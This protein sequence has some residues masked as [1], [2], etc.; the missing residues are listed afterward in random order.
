M[1]LLRLP[2]FR[3]ST[4]DLPKQAVVARPQDALEAQ[5]ARLTPIATKYARTKVGDSAPEVVQDAFMSLWDV[6]YGGGTETPAND[7]DKL[8]YRILRRRIVDELRDVRR[9]KALDTQHVLDISAYLE[10]ST[11]N[12]KVAEGEL[13]KGRIEYVIGAMPDKMRTA[14]LMHR[15]GNS[16]HEIASAMQIGVETARWHVSEAK[17]RVRSQLAKD[18]YELPAPRRRGTTGV[19]E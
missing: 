13:M 19:Q 12:A 8:F 5:M 2:G 6:A 14:F 9:R 3:R 4:P 16:A 17:E 1:R 18:G 7:T 11:N 15:D 10:A